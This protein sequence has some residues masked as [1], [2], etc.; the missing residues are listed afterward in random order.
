M[1]KCT[2]IVECE[3]EMLCER[4][5]G[6]TFGKVNGGMSMCMEDG[7]AKWRL[8]FREFILNVKKIKCRIMYVYYFP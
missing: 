4:T 3:C 5:E 2:Y 1:D 6:W 7:T 8:L